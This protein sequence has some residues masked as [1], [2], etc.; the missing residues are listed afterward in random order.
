MDV[1]WVTEM[2]VINCLALLLFSS[3]FLFFQRANNS[4]RYQ[5]KMQF[6]GTQN[7]QMHIHTYTQSGTFFLYDY[8][9]LLLVAVWL[10][11]MYQF[12]TVSANQTLENGDS[13][14]NM[15]FAHDILVFFSVFARFKNFKIHKIYVG[16]E[17][18]IWL[19]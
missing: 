3:N 10:R 18:N 1:Q 12:S 17:F 11:F 8:Y 13:F 15:G 5:W 9:Y 19:K 14:F 2:I 6:Q 4:S 16:N 7:T